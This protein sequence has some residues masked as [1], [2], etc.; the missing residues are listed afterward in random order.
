[1]CLL[2]NIGKAITLDFH[3]DLA[4]TELYIKVYGYIFIF[5]HHCYKGEQLLKV[6]FPSVDHEALENGINSL[7]KEFAPSGAN[8]FL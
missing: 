7:R 2:H 6:H 5:L 4:T 8:S 3:A 1:M